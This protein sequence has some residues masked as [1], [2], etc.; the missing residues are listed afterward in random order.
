MK[1]PNF[2][3]G[4][5]VSAHSAVGEQGFVVTLVSIRSCSKKLAD[6]SRELVNY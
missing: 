6:K 3:V 1:S 2:E 4:P 5:A